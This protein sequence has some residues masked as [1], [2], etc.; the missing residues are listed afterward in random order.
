MSKA[1]IEVLFSS[2]APYLGAG[3]LLLGIVRLCLY[4]YYFGVNIVDYIELSEIITS[5]LDLGAGFIIALVFLLICRIGVLV[6]QQLILRQPVKGDGIEVPPHLPKRY[7][8]SSLPVVFIVMGNI[9][10]R[11][12]LYVLFEVLLVVIAA[13]VVWAWRAW[14]SNKKQPKRSSGISFYVIAFSICVCIT[15]ASAVN[16]IHSVRFSHRYYG[17]SIVFNDQ[18][19]FVSDGQ[20]YYIGKCKNYL[21]IYHQD[22]D[23][24]EVI[25]MSAVQKMTLAVDTLT[26]EVC[27]P[28]AQFSGK[29]VGE[30][31]KEG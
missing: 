5:L 2:V 26:P 12:A 18:P 11:P 27:P 31:R 4:Y 8:L 16:S 25:P 7:I 24:T 9:E 13:L 30:E 22:R 10:G 15:V 1:R 14:S 20:H 6:F 23:I 17:T 21:F 3:I 19:A 28:P 29:R